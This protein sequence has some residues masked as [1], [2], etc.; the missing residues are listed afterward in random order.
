[1]LG[2]TSLDPLRPTRA[3]TPRRTVHLVT[4]RPVG[5]SVV[6]MK[7]VDCMGPKLGILIGLHEF[8]G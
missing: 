4:L 3:T 1:M 8:V 2:S 7:H 5:G 6:D